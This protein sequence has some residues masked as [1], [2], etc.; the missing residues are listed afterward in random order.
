MWRKFSEQ[1]IVVVCYDKLKSD[2]LCFLLVSCKKF[3]VRLDQGLKYYLHN[4]LICSQ[5]DLSEFFFPLFLN[6]L[7]A[8]EQ[9]ETCNYF[10]I[11][12]SCLR[13]TEI[14]YLKLLVFVWFV[15][16]SKIALI[17]KYFVINQISHFSLGRHEFVC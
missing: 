15:K 12:L 7:E 16:K 13:A 1:Q 11:E 5:Y 9:R 17:L 10:Q 4:S 14:R 8:D 2:N 3:I 6:S